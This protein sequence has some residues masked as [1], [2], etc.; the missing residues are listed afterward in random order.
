MLNICNMDYANHEKVAL[1][2]IIPSLMWFIEE[3]TVHFLKELALKLFLAMPHSSGMNVAT[4][5][6][7]SQLVL[8]PEVTPTGRVRELLWECDAF[9]VYMR[10][11]QDGFWYVD[12]LQC[13]LKWRR[14]DLARM[15]AGMEKRAEYLVDVFSFCGKPGFQKALE[16]LLDIVQVRIQLFLLSLGVCLIVVITNQESV[17]VNVAMRNGG[18]IPKILVGLKEEE[19]NPHAQ[20]NLLKILL[21]LLEV[22]PKGTVDELVRK[23]QLVPVIRQIHATTTKLLVKNI[24]QRLLAMKAFK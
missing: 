19:K 2:G 1:A 13:I 3:G 10:L 6:H 23:H 4:T 20:C 9:P 18:V 15:D 16:P 14:L 7:N 24:A 17:A 22:T 12:V 5:C 11:L 21:A 8:I